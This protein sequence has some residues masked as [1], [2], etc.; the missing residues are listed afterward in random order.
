MTSVF[1]GR[2]GV[3][4]ETAPGR[5]MTVVMRGI[6]ADIEREVEDVTDIYVDTFRRFAPS[7]RV[8]IELE[9][10]LIDQSEGGAEDAAWVTQAAAEIE[11]P[12]PELE[13]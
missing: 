10:H 9:G 8:R 12:I 2:I 6:K 3:V 5:F 4:I 1:A 13:G 11:A 7:N